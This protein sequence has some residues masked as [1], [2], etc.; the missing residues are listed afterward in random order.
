MPSP[1]PKRQE[2]SD[3]SANTASRVCR[4]AEHIFLPLTLLVVWDAAVRFGYVPRTL[5]ASPADVILALWKLSSNG[6]L[7]HHARISLWRL[8]VGFALGVSAGCFLGIAVGTSRIASKLIE[9]TL[10]ALIPVPP[11]AWIPLLIVLMGIGE[12][13]KI[14]LIAIGCFCTLFIHTAHAVRCSDAKLVE[15][16]R[17]LRKTKVDMIWHL[18]LPSAMPTVIAASR[19]AMALSWTLLLCAEIIASSRGLGWLIWDSRNFS[20]ADDMIAG[21]IT[22]A[23]LGKLTDLM[24]QRIENMLTPWQSTF[25]SVQID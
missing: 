23:A 12:S 18:F 13:S 2:K 25:R 19:V 15:L 22:V 14:M 10:L 1:V 3:V 11:I 9:P 4:F 16:A 20:R 8:T 7:F 24:L 21:M 5:I 6:D 17:A